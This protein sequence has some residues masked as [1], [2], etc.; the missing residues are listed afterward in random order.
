[1]DETKI[2]N[3]LIELQESVNEVKEQLAE[4]PTRTEVNSQ[5]DRL[6]HIAER[7]DQEKTVSSYRPDE[8]DVRITKLE[9]QASLT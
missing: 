2:L 5:F 4:K 9:Q 6:A 8:H 1:M 7:L 3:K